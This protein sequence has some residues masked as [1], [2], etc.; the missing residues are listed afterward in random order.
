[1]ILTGLT[2]DSGEMYQ[3][4]FYQVLSV[5]EELQLCFR[6]LSLMGQQVWQTLLWM[7]ARMPK[8]IWS[9]NSWKAVNGHLSM[10]LKSQCCTRNTSSV[11]RI[12]QY[13]AATWSP[14]KCHVLEPVPQ[15]EGLWQGRAFSFSQ[16][17]LW[18]NNAFV[19]NG[20]HHLH[21]CGVADRWLPCQM[22]QKPICHCY[23]NELLWPN[24]W[25][26]L[27]AQNSLVRLLAANI[28]FL[29]SFS[30]KL[31]K[32][33]L[34]RSSFPTTKWLCSGDQQEVCGQGENNASNFCNFG[35]VLPSF[36]SW[37]LST[38]GP[39]W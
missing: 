5:L 24:W 16:K 15:T 19:G 35:L 28:W 2:R 18:E 34:L 11:G 32:G 1:M 7:R 14:G 10:Q 4:Y 22:G 17:A 33:T 25:H 3:T 8:E 21:P 9:E 30:Q 13:V 31:S 37:I 29:K 20:S 23:Y 36:D 39:C 26:F 38:Q 6:M 12:Y 27:Q